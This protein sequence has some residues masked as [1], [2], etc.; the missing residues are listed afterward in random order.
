MLQE[1]GGYMVAKQGGEDGMKADYRI[2]KIW[3]LP[4]KE[5]GMG[6]SSTGCLS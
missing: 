6:N 2:A 4:K 1:I 5:I 3:K